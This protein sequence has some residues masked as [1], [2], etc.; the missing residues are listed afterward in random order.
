MPRPAATRFIT[1]ITLVA[2]AAADRAA[3]SA[4]P[5]FDRSPHFE[6]QVKTYTF[7]PDVTVHINAP[8]AAAF[9]PLKPTRLVIYALPNGNTIAQTIGR[10]PG[11]DLDWHFLIQHIG[12][13]TRLLRDVIDDQNLVVAYV[14]AGGRS[15]PSWR[16]THTD[17]GRH[18]AALIDSIRNPFPDKTTTVELAG[19]SGGGSLIFG[20]IDHVETIPPWIRRIVFLDANY[21]FSE[22]QKHGRKLIRWLQAAPDDALGIFAYDDRN[23][24]LNGKR[25]VGPTGG[26]YRQTHRMLERLRKDLDVAHTPHPRGDHYQALGGRLDVIILSNPDNKILHTVMVEKNGFAY[27]MTF[28]TP[29][30]G[31][32]GRFF[33]PAAY[34]Q[35]IQKDARPLDQ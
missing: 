11:P 9:D 22:E 34:E 2:T 5:G 24:E 28:A 25:I 26:T 30:A 12:A 10:Q 31:Q 23:V 7:D 27:A 16:H 20:F 13:Q 6:E 15:W 19:H 4:I 3:G 32:A 1:L 29:R 14:E 33:G 35:W 21:G 8:S 18:I 17:S